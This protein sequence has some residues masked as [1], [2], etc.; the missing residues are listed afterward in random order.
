[1]TT[2]SETA[3]IISVAS[4]IACF[5]KAL[6]WSRHILIGDSFVEVGMIKSSLKLL[7][8]RLHGTH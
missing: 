6:S 4:Q 1:M 5:K 8:S 7:N 2:T 3:I